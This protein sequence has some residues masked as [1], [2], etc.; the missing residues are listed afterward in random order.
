MSSLLGTRR[1]ERASE[2]VAIG[3]PFNVDE[4]LVVEP[5]QDDCSDAATVSGAAAEGNRCD[6]RAS[7]LALLPDP[8]SSHELGWTGIEPRGVRTR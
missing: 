5:T 6:R 2:L 4:L 8:I 3:P 1:L 7:P